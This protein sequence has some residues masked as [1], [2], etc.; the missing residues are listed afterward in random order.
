MNLISVS[1]KIIYVLS[2]QLH[3]QG[4]QYAVE[5]MTTVLA[6]GVPK[7]KIL[8]HC[9]PNVQHSQRAVGIWEVGAEGPRGLEALTPFDP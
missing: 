8:H 5:I 4:L 3:E 2:Q 7:I 1:K 6:W 9:K